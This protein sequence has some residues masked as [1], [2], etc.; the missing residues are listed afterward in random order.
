MQQGDETN[1]FEIVTCQCSQGLAEQGPHMPWTGPSHSTRYPRSLP[2]IHPK[3]SRDL[4]AAPGLLHRL[5]CTAQ[6]ASSAPTACFPHLT[7]PI[8]ACIWGQCPLPVA[9]LLRARWCMLGPP[10]S[11]SSSSA[12]DERPALIE[13]GPLPASQS[14]QPSSPSPPSCPGSPS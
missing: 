13:L 6:P 14:T 3:A 10:V 5:V 12:G 4:Q 9:W 2:H 7:F 11:F 1:Q 8:N